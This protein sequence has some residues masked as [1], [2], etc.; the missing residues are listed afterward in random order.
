MKKLIEN[1]YKQFKYLKNNIFLHRKI[2]YN[3]FNKIQ[4]VKNLK[5]YIFNT[6]NFL[7]KHY[8]I[9]I[10]LISY[11]LLIVYSPI[12]SVIW[13]CLPSLYFLYKR[14]YKDFFSIWGI[15][16]FI[17]HSIFTFIFLDFGPTIII[18]GDYTKK[19]LDYLLLN[20][21]TLWFIGLCYQTVYIFDFFS[22]ETGFLIC[23]PVLFP[24]KKTSCMPNNTQQNNPQQNRTPERKKGWFGREVVE[25]AKDDFKQ[26]ASM[27]DKMQRHNFNKF[28]KSHTEISKDGKRSVT[29]SE[30]YVPYLYKTPKTSCTGTE[31][32][33]KEMDIIKSRKSVNKKK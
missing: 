3:K 21:G 11:Y 6:N 13:L 26:C 24:L 31:L 25:P 22:Q 5:T 30:T 12:F 33:K 17:W 1:L 28:T 14:N 18:G 19:L 2:S 9:I 15:T 23:I 8:I 4:I 29:A 7:R 32:S 10:S 20:D 16:L 27:A